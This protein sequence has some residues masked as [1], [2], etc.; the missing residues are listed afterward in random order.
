MD[1]LNL[2]LT[3][4]IDPSKFGNTNVVLT[5]VDVRRCQYQ[6]ALEY[7][8]KE[9]VF[10]NIIFVENSGAAFDI[11]RY[12]RMALEENKCF[13]YI[14]A[15][16]DISMTLLKGKSYGE[17]SCIE[18]GVEK[19]ILLK[20]E[21]CF[22]KMTGRILLKNSSSMLTNGAVSSFLFRH[23]LQRCYTYFFKVNI[24]DYKKYFGKVKEMCDESKDLDIERAF[25]DIIMSNKIPVSS[26]KTYPLLD[27]VIG[28][29]GNAY[30]DKPVVYKTKVLLTKLGLYSKKGRWL[31]GLVNRFAKIRLMLFR[32]TKFC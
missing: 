26:F 1:N 19:S 28:T 22:Y 24:S 25:Y 16:T 12:K 4:T 20:N 21:K 32:K 7:Y 5:N 9:S 23:D 6:R 17:A 11:E 30:Q 13:E 31:S 27:G 29:T 18:Q 15:D 8:I 10:D 2:L 14:Y 3:G